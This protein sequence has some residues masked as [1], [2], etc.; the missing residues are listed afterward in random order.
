[1]CAASS[2][3]FSGDMSFLSILLLSALL[4]SV[5]TG[6]ATEGYDFKQ[7]RTTRL[8]SNASEWRQPEATRR[9]RG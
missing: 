4:L 5:F 3:N 1:F 9:E 7:S 8:T 2:A 6:F